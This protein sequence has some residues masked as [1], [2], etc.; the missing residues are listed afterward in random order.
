M[1]E[2]YMFSESTN[3]TGEQFRFL[4]VA[5][6]YIRNLLIRSLS[7]VARN[8][9]FGI[10]DE[11]MSL[12]VRIPVFGVSDQGRHKPVSTFFTTEYV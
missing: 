11:Q 1:K 4:S 8:S 7:L 10:S 6:V 9:F 2:Q 12:V 5:K 3:D